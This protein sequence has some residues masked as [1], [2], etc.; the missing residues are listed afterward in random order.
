MLMSIQDPQFQEE[1]V[2]F[3]GQQGPFSIWKCEP[4]EPYWK[5]TLKDANGEIKTWDND[6]WVE[7]A[8]LRRQI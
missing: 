1:D 6:P 7:E 5:Y 4:G 2:V 8:D 3:V